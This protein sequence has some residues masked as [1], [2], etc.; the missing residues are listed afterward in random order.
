[1]GG[2]THGR[3]LAVL[4]RGGSSTL[5]IST[6]ALRLLAKAFPPSGAVGCQEL[7][8]RLLL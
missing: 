6:F 1:M 5:L 3:V 4:N 7:G 8:V 2:G